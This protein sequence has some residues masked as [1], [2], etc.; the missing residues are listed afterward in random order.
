MP[1]PNS[2]QE[3]DQEIILHLRQNGI[4][5][6]RSEDALFNRY[7]Y[8]V[9]EG[10][11]KHS[12]SE[13]DAFN[14]YSDSVLAAIDRI[15]S[16]T[17]QGR[18]SLKTYLY[19]IFHNKCVD[20]LRKKATNKHSVYRTESISNMLLHITDNA[21]SVVQKLVDQAD[22]R[23]LRERLNQL[24]ND[25]RKM[26]LLWADNYSDKEIAGVLE[27]KTADVVKTSR[28]RCLEKLKRLYKN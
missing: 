14:A 7:A 3:T 17:F 26:L 12:I 1:I 15:I 24:N 9:R 6:R 27:Y 21:R 8:F 2:S 22:W 4:D 25:C 11:T 28:L 19:Q 10:M 13:D 16:G 23:Q 18:S 5:R 20:L